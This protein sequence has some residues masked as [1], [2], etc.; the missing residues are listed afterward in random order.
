MRLK[1]KPA[2]MYTAKS[3][4]V[5]LILCLAESTE[6]LVLAFLCLLT[7]SSVL[8]SVRTLLS[9]KELPHKV[10]MKCGLST[11]GMLQR[12]LPL[13]TAVYLTSWVLMT[14][15]LR[16]SHGLTQPTPTSLSTT[17][18]SQTRLDRTSTL[19]LNQVLLSSSS[20]QASIKE[21]VQL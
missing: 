5:K 2:A 21:D 9:S 7:P 16:R 12:E 13:L 11:T 1:S 6:P 15:H 3:Q 18:S 19:F 10:L 8:V 17:P 20:F 14:V 4:E